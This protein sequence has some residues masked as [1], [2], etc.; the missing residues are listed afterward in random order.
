MSEWLP[1]VKDL[2]DEDKRA[3]LLKISNTQ[4]GC[5]PPAAKAVL[6]I[7]MDKAIERIAE[8]FRIDQSTISA[9]EN[10]EQARPVERN[11]IELPMFRSMVSEARDDIEEDSVVLA[12]YELVKKELINTPFCQPR[13]EFLRRSTK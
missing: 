2:F 7:A 1:E 9:W 3:K 11:V 5:I 6:M 10:R 4:C 8:K 12:T 13:R